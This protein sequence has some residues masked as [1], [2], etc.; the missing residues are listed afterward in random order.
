MGYTILGCVGALLVLALFF[1]IGRSVGFHAG[2]DH[3]RQETTKR[4]SKL[5]NNRKNWGV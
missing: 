3:E 2:V 4:T 5:S 1:V